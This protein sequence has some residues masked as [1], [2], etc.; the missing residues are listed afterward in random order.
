MTLSVFNYHVLRTIAVSECRMILL[1][2]K[3]ELCKM[4]WNK[5]TNI[6]HNNYNLKDQVAEFAHWRV[7]SQPYTLNTI[8][9]NAFSNILDQPGLPSS[10]NERS[11]FAHYAA[12]T[13]RTALHDD[14]TS[15]WCVNNVRRLMGTSRSVLVRLD[16]PTRLPHS[17]WPVQR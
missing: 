12:E 3:Q 1:Q 5:V 11:C 14:W 17:T 8:V 6:H 7:K 13:S 10:S 9:T 2:S 4:K 16:A 15:R